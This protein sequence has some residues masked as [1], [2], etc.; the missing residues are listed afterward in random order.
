M[1]KNE[2]IPT[3]L[4]F[5]TKYF[6]NSFGDVLSTF[7]KTEQH[8]LLVLSPTFFKKWCYSA[9]FEDTVLSPANILNSYLNK[10]ENEVAYF[11]YKFN[12]S[13]RGNN[14][15]TYQISVDSVDCHSFIKNLIALTEYCFPVA[16]FEEDG[17]FPFTIP[18]AL[19]EKLT[20]ADAFYFEYLILMAQRLNLITAMPS[21][22]TCKF[23]KNKAHCDSFFSKNSKQILTLLTDE[24]F[25]IFNLKFIDVLQLPNR[26]VNS[27]IMRSF[28]K[29]SITID[30]IYDKIY[31]ALGFDFDKMLK[32]AEI[33]VLSPENEMLMSSAYLMGT[34]LDKWFFSPLG[35]YLKLVTPLYSAPYDFMNE[36][37][38]V[39]PILLTGCDVSADVFSPCNYFSLTPI[40]EDV[41]GYENPNP[42]FQNISQDFSEQQIQLFLR[43]MLEINGVNVTDCIMQN[44]NREIYTIKVKYTD[45]QQLWKTIQV[46]EDYTIP[47]LYNLIST[48]FGFY[49]SD[50]YVFSI[51]S[52]NQATQSFSQIDKTSRFLLNELLHNNNLLLSDEFNNFPDL[53]LSL[54][55]ISSSKDICNYPR[56]L[57]Q[58]RA[59]TLEEL[60]DNI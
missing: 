39:R 56:L 50:N 15:F 57:R 17:L 24:V 37:D 19:A 29:E 36:L 55:G 34:V 11:S 4:T 2:F 9:F 3:S 42:R 33:P 8:R 6:T 52:K 48:Y 30:D 10:N 47:K 32:M 20:T 31:S 49:K 58:S 26:V 38:Y 41:L 18:N 28:L 22:N 7:T 27:S 12:P 5:L 35:D 44:K 45:A 51:L 53:E 60:N 59:I 25:E 16:T 40:G 23:Q 13:G 21:I 54:V 14:K 46:P 1:R 43:S